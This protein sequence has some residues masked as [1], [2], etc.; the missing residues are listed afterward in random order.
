[1]KNF[2]L[3]ILLS[4]SLIGFSQ[5][6]PIDFEDGGQGANW[7]W[8]VFENAD[9][10]PLE[11]V[12]NPDPSGINQSAMVA[13][14]TARDTNAGAAP[15]AGL[16]SQHGGN[17]GTFDLTSENALVNIMVYKTKISDVGIKFAT[18]TGGA[19]TEIKV[20]NTLVNQWEQITID[21]SGY[22]GLG[23]TTGLDQ[24]IIFPDFINRTADDIIYFDNITF[25]ETVPNTIALPITL[26]DGQVPAFSD[27]NGSSTLVIDNPDPSG[28]NT[29][30]TVAQNTVPAGAA[31]A[32]VNYPVNNIDITTDKVFSLSVWS[33]LPNIPVLL[34]LENAS[35]VNTERAAVTTSTNAWETINFDFTDEGQLT[36]QSV[37]IFMNFNMTDPADQVYY[38]DNLV[39]GEPLEVSENTMADISIYPN[40]A[41]S[42]LN[43]QASQQIKSIQ[44]FNLLG[45]NVF[46]KPVNSKTS[47]LE[48]AQFNN[49]VYLAKVLFDNGVTQTLKLIKK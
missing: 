11:F 45:Q 8:N 33:P 10:P 44:L 3:L 6:A 40:P 13:K 24:I 2:T 7:G 22:I 19:Q 16:E 46:H 32:G 49:G 26:E 5:N 23:E 48:V 38:W 17:I 36:Y 30:A 35:G 39:L 12:S 41:T 28:A 34:K 29:S 15:Y 20:A 4:I 42:V 9:N 1:M 18:P 14:F 25:G 43:L 31:F 27:F 37:T 21:F 47:I